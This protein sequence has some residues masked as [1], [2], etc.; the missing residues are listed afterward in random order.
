MWGEKVQQSTLNKI[1]DKLNATSGIC[2]SNK[3]VQD[4]NERCCIMEDVCGVKFVVK[5]MPEYYQE[6]QYEFLKK[7]YIEA[8]CV[9]KPIILHKENNENY[10]VYVYCT[11]KTAD[12]FIGNRIELA[13]VSKEIAKAIKMLHSIYCQ[14]VFDYNIEAEIDRHINFLTKNKIDFFAKK[15]FIFALKN[16]ELKNI[17]YG[18]THMDLHLRNIV[19]NSDYKAIFIDYDNISIS[20][21][22]RDFVYA[23]AMHEREENDLW[24]LVL[25]EYFNYNISDA[26]WNDMY[27]Y[28]IIHLFRMIEQEFKNGNLDSM[29]FLANSLYKNYRGLRTVIPKWIEE[30][31]SKYEKRE[32]DF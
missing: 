13:K 23:V 32:F 24:Y 18:F 16:I 3:N 17:Q 14:D 9:M 8:N 2:I 21:I 27:Y 10:I 20:D 22:R 1:I 5:K 12:S 7:I 19:I 26:F 30:R 15:D 6:V 25:Q 4:F 29:N 11:G 28:T 31:N